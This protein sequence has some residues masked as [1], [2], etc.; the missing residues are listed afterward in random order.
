MANANARNNFKKGVT[1][2]LILTFLQEGD[3][4]G[5]QISQ[6]LMERSDGEFSIPEGSLYPALYKL[7]EQGYI[8]DHKEL[9]GKRMTRVY[10]HLENSG[11][12]HLEQLTADYWFV[13]NNIEK[14]LSKSGE[15]V[16]N[17][18]KSE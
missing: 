14:I 7:I 9:V 6:T 12:E 1:A 15:K 17:H 18:E 10:Y 2:L 8:S 16:S 4:Y 5:Y 13:R 11:R 3:M